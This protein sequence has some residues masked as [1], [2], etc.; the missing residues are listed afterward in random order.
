M[1]QGKIEQTFAEPGRREVGYSTLK[2]FVLIFEMEDF[3]DRNFD[4]TGSV[5]YHHSNLISSAL[6]QYDEPRDMRQ[7]WEV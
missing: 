5:L 7:R 1:K 6:Q 3:R 2:H 4:G